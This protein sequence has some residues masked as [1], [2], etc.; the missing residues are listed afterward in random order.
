MPAYAWLAD[1]LNLLA[2]EG[3]L[4]PGSTLPAE[5]TLAAALG[6][7]RTTVVRAL[8][9]AE[10]QGTL[11]ARRGSGR[12]VAATGSPAP[13]FEPL[14]P[15]LNGPD[16]HQIDLRSSQMPPVDDIAEAMRRATKAT[17][18][19][20][21]PGGYHTAGIPELRE[22]VCAH[23]EARGLPTA[24]D[25]VLITTGAV[26]GAHLAVRAL[27][28]QSRRVVVENPC[29][30][31]T[32]R[33]V[34][35]IGAR[36]LPV[37]V[38]TDHTG[39]AVAHALAVSGATC[40]LLIPEFQNPT[41][42]L[43]SAAARARILDA[44]RRHN[45]A[46]IVDETLVA[47][48]WRH[49]DMPAPMVARGATSVLI[50]SMSKSHWAG[51]RIGWIRAPRSV[52]AVISHQR[53]GADLGAPLHEQVLAA[54]LL[55]RDL[56]PQRWTQL[57]DSHDTLLHEL[58]TRLP[59]WRVEP[60]DGGLNVWCRL[61]SRNSEQLVR[62]AA[63]RGVLLASGHVFSPTGHGW[64]ARLRLPFTAAAHDLVRAVT[65]LAEVADEP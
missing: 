5:R 31:N 58:H 24:P 57:A 64:G 38:E 30:P 62:A 7:S 39:E 33:T 21:T 22:L 60:V 52:L 53:L 6:L 17:L 61:P 25:Q 35:F 3:R 12:T 51:L 50:G 29:Y 56:P 37:D 9:L 11:T 14:Q 16:A 2:A 42:R 54:D 45:V 36:C 28:G 19:L 40:A 8:T 32:V 48:N 49:L 59:T 63:R 4:A 65:I 10:A 47:A 15:G 34:E 27:A 13:T 44:A 41:G 43:M 55:M 18:R 1:R 23:Y 20:L 46:L 26:N